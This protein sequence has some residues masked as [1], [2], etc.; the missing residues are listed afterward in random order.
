MEDLLPK[1]SDSLK[2]AIEI[3]EDENQLLIELK[4]KREDFIPRDLGS[5]NEIREMIRIFGGVTQEIPIDIDVNGNSKTVS[6]KLQNK[7]DYDI[8]R[9]AM[10]TIWERAAE[11][12]QKAFKAEPGK[13]EE[14]RV[15]GDFDENY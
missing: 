13:T 4:V 15:L 14:F 8:I 12:L 7:E 11:L 6:L 10:K 9:T 3:T 1:L 2:N 5:P